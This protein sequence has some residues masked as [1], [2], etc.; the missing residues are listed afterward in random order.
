MRETWQKAT[1]K[2]RQ[3]ILADFTDAE[4]D[5]I[6]WWVVQFA[7]DNQ[8]PPAGD[9]VYWVILAGRGFGKTRAG[10]ELVRLWA[11][12]E[13]QVNLIG[14]TADDARDIMIEGESGIL[15][16]CPKSERP[17]YKKSD[18]A[19][20]WPNGGKS[21][22]FTADEPERLR[23]KQHSKLWMDELCSWRYVQESFDQAMFGLR[24]GRNPQ[25]V[26]TTTPRPI[27]QLKALLADHSTVVT[28]GSTYDN[29]ANL[30]QV[31]Y[32]KITTR[33]EGTRLGR[34]E[35]TAE[36]LDDIE[37][38][39]WNNAMLDNNR[40][41]HLPE[42]RRI[43]VSIDPAVS[44]NKASNETGIIVVGEGV[45][46]HYYPLMDVSGIY[47]P[48]EWAMKAIHQYERHKASAIVC[49]VN[50]G[51]D[52]VE[53]NLRAAGF[54]GRVIKVHATKGKATRAEPVVGMYE[55]NK[56]HHLGHLPGLESQMLTWDPKSEDSPDRID[57]LVWAVTELINGVSN[58]DD[59]SELGRVEEYSN[60]WR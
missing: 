26:I 56:V 38:A 9:W 14:A 13:R 48:L 16:I 15:A 6:N 4:V 32:E 51:G 25:A 1:P 58:W 5:A 59:V 31:F 36:I 44:T 3:K 39:L 29:K 30:A 47:S 49:E 11:R 2:K 34:Q 28:K 46:N 27:K 42:L 33:Y 53:A 21:L 10:A 23:G 40:V 12:T 17:V 43:L 24:L 60:P 50:N 22:I 37:G 8:L 54:T 35:L 19:L 52:L 7:R 41:T 45:D 20:E 18:R 55:Q 57:A